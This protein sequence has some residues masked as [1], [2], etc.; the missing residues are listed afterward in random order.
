MGPGSVRLLEPDQLTTLTTARLLA[1]R[2][3]LLALEQ[4]P[5]LSDWDP[6]E[7]AALDPTKVYFK[8]DPRWQRA[9][10]ELK[11]VLGGREHVERRG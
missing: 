4:S 6:H 10:A 8:D 3:K 11:E 5:E 1:Y 7:L 2:D 9:Y